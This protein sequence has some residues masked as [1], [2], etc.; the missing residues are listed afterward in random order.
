M[1]PPNTLSRSEDQ[2][3]DSRRGIVRALLLCAIVLGLCLAQLAWRFTLPGDGWLYPLNAPI[4]GQQFILEAHL[5]DLPTELQSGDTLLA[6]DGR[7]I[8]DIVGEALRL[9]PQPPPAW[10]VGSQ[11]SYEVLQEGD[12]RT[13]AVTL[14]SRTIIQYLRAARVMVSSYIAILANCAIALAVFLLRPRHRAAQFFLVYNAFALANVL[15]LLLGGQNGAPAELYSYAY[16]PAMVFNVLIYPF[17][18]IPAMA[19]LFLIFPVVKRPMRRRPRTTVALLY[20]GSLFVMIPVLALN[21]SE[22]LLFWPQVLTYGGLIVYPIAA[23]I[24]LASLIHTLLNSKSAQVVAQARWLMLGF[25]LSWVIGDGVLWFLVEG[26]VIP[27]TPTVLL[28]MRLLVLAYPITLAIAI[29]RY[30]LFDIEVIIRRTTTYA[31]LTGSLLLIYFT[32]V[33]LLQRLFTALTGQTSTAAIVLSTLLIAALFLPLRRRIQTVIDR[34]FFRQ[35]YDAEQVLS[36]FA[37]TA[38]DETDLDALTAELVRVIQE[39]MQPESVSVWLLSDQPAGSQEREA[40][41]DTP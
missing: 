27:E 25:V 12:D 2:A 14:E 23:V 39:T 3:N 21:L 17:I 11:V 35:K 19:H 29:L 8:E 9:Q 6:V 34:R 32:S 40:T 37:A 16:W 4:T 22:P 24:V 1:R 7:P 10:Q 20:G 38:R 41:D 33:V 30:Q 28:L 15:S 26:G 13:V 36:Q 31:L 18:L 5:S